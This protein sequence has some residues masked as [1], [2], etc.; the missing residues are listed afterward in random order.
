[1]LLVCVVEDLDQAIEYANQSR[2]GLTAA[3]FTNSKLKAEQAQQEI[4]AGM[5]YINDSMV[6]SDKTPWCGVKDSA[7]GV[8]RSKHGLWEFTH[9]RH[10]Y[11]D[12]SGNKTREWWFPYA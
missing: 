12:W 1:V 10:I 2:Y 5:V 6:L 11:A 4:E 3:V 7:V 8:E 9:K